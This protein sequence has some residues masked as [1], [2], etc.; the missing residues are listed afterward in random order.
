MTGNWKLMLTP[1]V[2][3]WFPYYV[4]TLQECVIA[5]AFFVKVE[6]GQGREVAS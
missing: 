4:C 5:V 2:A 1:G 6:D 3:K